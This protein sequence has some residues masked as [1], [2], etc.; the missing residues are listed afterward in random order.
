MYKAKW[1][2]QLNNENFSAEKKVPVWKY[3]NH[4]YFISR[5]AKFRVWKK[6]SFQGYIFYLVRREKIPFLFLKNYLFTNGVNFIP[7]NS[8]W[9]FKFKCLKNKRLTKDSL[10]YFCLGPGLFNYFIVKFQT[11]RSKMLSYL[12]MQYN[13]MWF[14]LHNNL[15]K[16]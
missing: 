5:G 7:L 4:V 10:T 12:N 6:V 14:T 2:K 9:I 13:V 15:F 11:H 1:Q 3:T 8:T 16:S